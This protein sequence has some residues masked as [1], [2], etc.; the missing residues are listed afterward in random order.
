[1][2]ARL[3]GIALSQTR[4]WRMTELGTRVNSSRKTGDT[5]LRR[6]SQAGCLGRQEQRRAPRSAP[7]RLAP[8]V[9]ARLLE[10]KQLPPAWGPRQLLPAL[11]RHHPARAWPAASS[12]GERFHQ[13]G[14]SRSQPRR[15]RP[16]PP[17]TPTLPVA[18][19]NAVWPAAGTGPCRTGDGG[20][21]SPLTVADA[22]SRERLG[23]TARRSTTPGEAPPVCARRGHEEGLPEASRTAHG[24]PVATPA[25]C[26]RSK[27]RVGW[28]TRGLRHQRI[29]P[30]R[31]EQQGRHERRPRTRTADATRPPAQHH[32]TQQARFDRCC[33]A[34]TPDRPHEARGQRT[35][36]ARSPASPRPMPATR[37]EPTA[38][39][40]DLVRRVSH[41]GT[42]RLTRRPR[43]LSDTWRQAWSA[44]AETGDGLWSISGSDGLLARVD[45]RDFTLRGYLSPMFPGSSVTDVPG[46]YTSLLTR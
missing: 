23:G 4:L 38:P 20:Y 30:G 27:R 5:W 2:T 1:M 25:G 40:H 6:D 3:S 18:S 16:Q 26:G 10:A 21:G 31:P 24:A 33:R 9:A 13:A 46:C 42:W 44:L 45:E 43:F 7:H 17:G 19:P 37:A 14:L 15:R 22:S 12:A 41:A 34:S 28:S 32:A 36:A 39:G 35:P 8:D 29:A 11:A